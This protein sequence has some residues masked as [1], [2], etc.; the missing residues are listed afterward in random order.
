MKSN[1]L[2]VLLALS[3]SLLVNSQTE[4]IE[5]LP[6]KVKDNVNS[7][8]TLAKS[9]SYNELIELC[10]F[11]KKENEAY[12]YVFDDFIIGAYFELKD[13]DKVI[14][15]AQPYVLNKKAL[16]FKDS[17]ETYLGQAYIMKERIS[18]GCGILEKIENGESDLTVMYYSNC[19]EHKEYVFTVS[20][21]QLN[22]KTNLKIKKGDVV[23]LTATGKVSYGMFTG[24]TGPE[25]FK[26]GAYKNYNRT[27]E[28]NHGEL[29]FTISSDPYLFYSL[30]YLELIKSSGAIVFH[31]N[32]KQVDNNSGSFNASIKVY[33]K[34][35]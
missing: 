4:K 13:F 14:E 26:N 23:V 33:S 28:M 5:N 18:E 32:D 29:F 11:Y 3:V 1:K 15:L 8:I 20:G 10:T 35:K 9:K 16:L 21:S 27:Q 12:N 31:I 2:L 19:F 22:T 7:I 6:E 25:G 30:N 24:Y 34:T 17:A